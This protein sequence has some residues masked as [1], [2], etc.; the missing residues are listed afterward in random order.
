MDRRA[1]L[2]GAAVVGLGSLVPG[3]AE[4]GEGLHKESVRLRKQWEFQKASFMETLLADRPGASD[5]AA[6]LS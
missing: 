1:F 4:A 3:V 2:G 6:H 5:C